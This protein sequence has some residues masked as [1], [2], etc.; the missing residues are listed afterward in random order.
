MAPVEMLYGP[1]DVVQCHSTE[2]HTHTHTHTHR[3]A[4]RTQ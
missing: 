3:D 2:L 4:I 1:N